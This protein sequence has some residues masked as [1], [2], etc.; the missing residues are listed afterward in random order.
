MASPRPV[1]NDGLAGTG[2]GSPRVRQAHLSRAGPDTR[3]EG[4]PHAPPPDASFRVRRGAKVTDGSGPICPVPYKP[5]GRVWHDAGVSTYKAVELE[6]AGRAPTGR[7]LELVAS[8][9]QE[10]IALLLKLLEVGP[11]DVQVD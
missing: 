1:V 6:R 3:P 8:T 7:T 2:A 10:A 4:A 9:R 5:A 11:D